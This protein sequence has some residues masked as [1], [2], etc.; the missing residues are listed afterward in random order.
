MKIKGLYISALI[1][2]F[3]GIVLAIRGGHTLLGIINLL[4]FGWNAKGLYDAYR[5]Y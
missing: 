5:G 2:G 3:I 1:F 4:L